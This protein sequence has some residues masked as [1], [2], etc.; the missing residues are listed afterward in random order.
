MTY[1]FENNRLYADGRMIYEAPA[2]IRACLKSSF[3]DSAVIVYDGRQF[4]ADL[5]LFAQPKLDD[6]SMQEKINQNILCIGS[7]GNILWR[8]EETSVIHILLISF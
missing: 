2:E 7:D 1:T 4:M 6:K 3:N 8:I 5:P